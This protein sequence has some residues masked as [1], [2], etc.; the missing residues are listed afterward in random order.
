MKILHYPHPL[1]LRRTQKVDEI[2]GNLAD[3]A[4][5]MLQAMRESN[6]VGLAANQVGLDIRMFV[7]NPTGEPADAIVMINPEI[8]ERAGEQMGEEGCLSFP[9]IFGKIP[10]HHEVVVEYYDLAGK[11]R[12]IQATDLLA[13]VCQHE[14]DH[15]DGIVFVSRMSSADRTIVSRRLKELE[16][17]FARSER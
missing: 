4:K 8:V 17:A 6:G 16:S 7:T 5:K 9:E 12:A 11:A 3:I 10:R 15:L 14:I 1:L 13:R 2:G